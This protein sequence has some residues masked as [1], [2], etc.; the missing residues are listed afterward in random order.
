LFVIPGHG[1][2]T[3]MQQVKRYTY[4]YLIYLRNKISVHLENGGELK[5]AYYIDQTPYNKLDTFDELATKN[6]GRVFQ[7]MEFE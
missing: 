5:E 7:E 6:A 1:H 2:P 4:D 3:N